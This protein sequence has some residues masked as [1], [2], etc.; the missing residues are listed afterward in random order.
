MSPDLFSVVSEIKEIN[1]SLN[2]AFNNLQ[3]IRRAVKDKVRCLVAAEEE[4]IHKKNRKRP[5]S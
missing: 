1:R 3:E 4:R 5:P 2:V